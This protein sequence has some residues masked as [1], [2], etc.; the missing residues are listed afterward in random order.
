MVSNDVVF[1][2]YVTG[3]PD[4]QT[5]AK[6]KRNLFKHFKTWARSRLGGAP[7][8]LPGIAGPDEFERIEVWY[9]SLLRVGC[10]AVIFHDGLS[11]AFVDRW[12]R[13][14]V[15][16]QHYELKTAR[17]VNDERYQCYYEYLQAHP[18]IERVFMLDLFDIEFF[19]NPFALLDD[20]GSDICCGGDA[21][22]YNDKMNRKKMITAFGEACYEDRI[23]L[24]AGICGGDRETVMTL[25][26]CMI[27]V[28]DGLTRRGE[29]A[30]LNMAI[31][32]KCVYDLHDPSRILYGHRLN[33]RFKKYERSGN[34]ALR[35]K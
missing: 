27:D 14:E 4:P 9:H 16:F 3:K 17:S 19:R 26:R 29:L 34:F 2:T 23:K 35:H 30:N 22:E 31:F 13:D 7:A 1:T 15:R 18:D 6:R 20:S 5:G 11:P 8:E 12:S 32:N 21:G 28:F 10:R 24:N 33:S 25:L